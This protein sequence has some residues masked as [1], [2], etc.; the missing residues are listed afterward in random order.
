[1]RPASWHAQESRFADT[2]VVAGWAEK[3]KKF[4][5]LH[6]VR[7]ES[8]QLGYAGKLDHGFSGDDARRL[9]TRLKPL[10]ISKQRIAAAR[11]FPKAHRHNRRRSFAASVFKG[12][13]EDL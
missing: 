11:K 9:L 10:H 1:M 2:F 7:E 8:G 4:D 13:R 12:V 6:L 3:N 5:G